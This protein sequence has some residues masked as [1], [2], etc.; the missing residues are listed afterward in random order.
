M[1]KSN[2]LKSVCVFRCIL[3]VLLLCS[4]LLSKGLDSLVLDQKG[5]RYR[6]PLYLKVL[7]A[8]DGKLY[9]ETEGVK[10]TSTSPLYK[11]VIRLSSPK[12][13]TLRFLYEDP[14]GEDKYFGPFVYV[15][16]PPEGFSENLPEPSLPA[17]IYDSVLVI[18]FKPIKNAAIYY[19]LNDSTKM[20]KYR[21]Q[22]LI[23]DTT[24]I[25]YYKAVYDSLSTDIFSERYEILLEPPRVMLTTR[26]RK[27]NFIPKIGIKLIKA[28]QAFYSLDPL[29]PYSSFQPVTNFIRLQEGRHLLRLYAT[30]IA[31]MVSQ[32][33][34]DYITVDATPPEVKYYVDINK[35]EARLQMS[36][37]GSV[38]FTTDGRLPDLKSKKYVKPISLPQN[39]VVPISFFAVDTMGN[40]SPISGF[41]ASADIYP[42][43]VTVTPKEGAFTIPV[44]VKFACSEP[45]A[46][47]YSLD[48]GSPHQS[49]RSLNEPP[50]HL[51]IQKEGKNS[52]KFFAKDEAGN[53]SSVFTRQFTIDTRPPD[54]KYKVKT[55]A[56]SSQLFP[57]FET[58]EPADIYYTINGPTPT[59]K[60]Q[61]FEEG[62]SVQP[63]SRFMFIAVDKLGNTTKPQLL[64]DILAPP[65]QVTPP[66]GIYNMALKVSLKSPEGKPVEWKCKWNEEN[67]DG[68][69][70]RRF[71][72]PVLLNRS[73]VYILAYRLAG[74]E[75]EGNLSEQMY[76]ID[77]EIPRVVPVIQKGDK[78]SAVNLL[79]EVSEPVKII[80]TIDGS[81]PRTPDALSAGSMRRDEEILIKIRRKGRIVFKYYAEDGAGNQTPV[82][83]LDIFSPHVTLQPPPGVY[84]NIIS[85]ELQ[86]QTGNIIYYSEDSVSLSLKSPVYSR[87]LIVKEPK[88]IWFFAV[89][90]TGFAGP[91]QKA[92]YRINLS[93]E[94]QFSV[95]G[96]KVM[97]GR[98]VIL[99]AGLSS[100]DDTPND[101]MLYRWDIDGDGRFDTQFSL[102]SRFTTRFA[103]Q[104]LHEVVLE[105]QD[106]SGLS[107][108]LRKPLKVFK[109][110]P[111]DMLSVF[112][113]ENS[114]C[115][116]RYE[117]AETGVEGPRVMVN[118][119]EA[120]ML[121]RSKGRRLCRLDEW[122]SA[123]KGDR[124]FI[125]S[126][127]DRYMPNKC[128][129]T[130]ESAYTP[131][132]RPQ[133]TSPEGVRDMVGNVWEWVDGYQ[134]GYH[135]VTGGSY[136]Q[137]E[138][139]SC[140]LTFPSPIV[141]KEKNI[142]FRCCE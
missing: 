105:V 33:F 35:R 10:P 92:R 18:S 64:K 58:N 37:K 29:A 136:L 60:S 110:C 8:Y 68:G 124:S 46:I 95:S 122:Q 57:E 31:G 77:R 129:T 48:G 55:L 44:K 19:A 96:G 1:M 106:S 91:K 107:A 98:A 34:R 76:I 127:G 118:W 126:Y 82:Y 88:T 61:R 99:D 97:A 54:V 128:N 51:L 112:G 138:A 5:R 101:K 30:N 81:S 11:G 39:G 89:S 45:C 121:C 22:Q 67:L 25:L 65:I 40:E 116:E 70:F 134:G 78:D 117:W 23:L 24:T 103:T 17:G 28:N 111:D 104:G 75:K 125:Y 123:C 85:V 90:M 2:I 4:P 83:E 74:K 41:R 13:Y 21:S 20:K 130:S 42:P 132:M 93:P 38:Y 120:S 71:T 52:L 69:V 32:E 131:G 119:A 87:P 114:F 16:T 73:G 109:S 47:R 62:L 14:M 115:I 72:D 137:G 113:E 56:S 100:D 94:P 80:Y 59:L 53:E 84:H 6:A 3:L 12:T 141:L 142:G 139:A 133:C 26:L 27:F 135:V 36:E 15:L 49:T 102:A 9:F 108:Q 140:T 7:S 79:F 63:K 66:G 50:M 43:D 86:S